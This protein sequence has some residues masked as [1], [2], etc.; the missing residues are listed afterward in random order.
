M[1][2]VKFTKKKDGFYSIELDNKDI[3][4]IHEDL[5]LKYDLLITRKLDNK[6]LNTIQELNE[7]YLI[8]NK[9]IKYIS[10]RMR[11]IF[12]VKDYLK[13]LECADDKI[14]EVVNKLIS[15]GY[16]DDKRYCF[17]Y[18]ND[19]INLSNDGPYKIKRNLL[20]QDFKEEDIDNYLYSIDEEIWKEKINKLIDKKKSIMQ[21]KSYYM[22]INKMKEYLFN[23]GYDNEQIDDYLSKIEYSSNAL[24]NDYNKA[25]KKYKNDTNKIINYLLR[26]G[27]NYEEIKTL[28]K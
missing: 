6:K 19:R 18:V 27:Y 23:L 20:E 24:E 5:I 16:L 28:T 25:L 4:L 13:K 3:F 17:A 11:S 21:N 8:Y 22:F 12:E 1:E 10:I 14:N 9:A 7:V 15:Q 2:I 26:K